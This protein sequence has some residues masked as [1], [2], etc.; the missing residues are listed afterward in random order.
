MTRRSHDG[1]PS[2]SLLARAR[3]RGIAQVQAYF[4]EHP[5]RP[6]E[7]IGNRY[8]I[9][10]EIGRGGF[11]HVYRARQLALGRRLVALKLI[12][13]QRLETHSDGEGAG[14]FLKLFEK[15]AL[16][17]SRLRHHNIVVVFDYGIWEKPLLG[18]LPYLVLEL[19]EGQSLEHR[20]RD[21]PLPLVEA[22]EQVRQ[23]LQALDH[24]HQRGIL[25][26]D[27]K[28]SNLFLDKSGFLKV[29]DFGLARLDTTRSPE[30]ETTELWH[31]VL[32]YAAT[33][34]YLPPEQRDGSERDVGSDLYA[35]GRILID[36][37]SGRRPA[38]ADTAGHDPSA[39]PK[40]S[41]PVLLQELL[42]SALHED[43]AKRFQSAG[44][45]LSMVEMAQAQLRGHGGDEV[46]PY[47]HLAPF[48]RE[49]SS[50]FFGRQR[51]IAA[52]RARLDASSFTVLIGTSGAGKTSLL[53]A[54]LLPTVEVC[55]RV[56]LVE[57]GSRPLTALVERLARSGGISLS[58][59][60]L[61][62]N[63]ELAANALRNLAER[64]G[65]RML[66]VVDQLEECFTQCR[67][68]E[69]RNAFLSILV[70]IANDPR[71]TMSVLVAIREDFLSRL[72]EHPALIEKTDD[73]LILLRPPAGDDLKAALCAPA[74]LRGFFFEPGLADAVL[75]EL[76]TDR[77]AAPLP[78]LQLV[79]T[80]L[81]EG[82][83]VTARQLRHAA[84][85][86][87]DGVAGVL[88]AHA[89]EALDRLRSSD[90][91]RLVP[92]IFCALVTPE[93]TRRTLARDHVLASF[94]GDRAAAEAV[95]ETLISG[96][97]LLSRRRDGEEVIE[98][99]HEALISRWPT[100]RVWLNEDPVVRRL[101]QKLNA[102]ALAWLAQGKPTD[103]LWRGERLALAR[104]WEGSLAH[105]SVVTE[106]LSRSLRAARRR[107]LLLLVGVLVSLT[108][109]LVFAV[110]ERY[111]AAGEARHAKS[112]RATNI[113][114][115][116]TK[117]QLGERTH[118]LEASY[119]KEKQ[120]TEGLSRELARNQELIGS[121]KATESRLR[122]AGR[123]LQETAQLARAK[124]QEAV[125][126]ERDATQARQQADE[127]L[128]LYRKSGPDVMEALNLLEQGRSR[129]ALERV[130]E[131]LQARHL[132]GLDIDEPDLRGLLLNAVVHVSERDAEGRAA[133]E[134][135]LPVADIHDAG[136]A[137]DNSLWLATAQGLYR[138]E[139]DARTVHPVWNRPIQRIALS[140]RHLLLIGQS[141]WVL[142]QP[143]AGLPAA[144]PELRALPLPFASGAGLGAEAICEDQAGTLH[145]A[146]ASQRELWLEPAL[147]RAPYG[148]SAE[149]KAL[150]W[151][152][153][154]TALA[155]G[156]L[157][158]QVH[159]WELAQPFP[160]RRTDS[161][162]G[163]R[164]IAVTALRYLP[165]REHLLALPL[166]G[167]LT[168]LEF[169][170]QQALAAPV[171][172][173]RELMRTL[174]TDASGRLAVVTGS[175]S[176][177]RLWFLTIQR[178]I[179]FQDDG[180]RPLRLARLSPDGNRL[181]LV[182]RDQ[183]ARLYRIDSLTLLRLGQR[184][185]NRG[186]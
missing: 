62:E 94:P 23:L 2:E 167:A 72:G 104:Q 153:A 134:W 78:L 180:G 178:S 31:Q 139:P 27:L 1:G 52:L 43:R 182:S 91:R 141:V 13:P 127:L 54:G 136:F 132:H 71:G 117:E 99:V 171:R 147:A 7:T 131:L 48:E 45:F 64:S 37:L 49:H 123:E 169:D 76:E 41:F 149:V 107:R 161:I 122:R 66:L 154:C 121:L 118:A 159:R 17:T 28:P 110:R 125:K 24:A 35:V 21:G 25:H 162:S 183:T 85:K 46:E 34:C 177:A 68:G 120:L 67:S 20:L 116:R 98:L 15:E 163:G 53:R 26:L 19:L 81:W 16:A 129:Q 38:T 82:R 135:R 142:S 160:S 83:D 10:A 168:R 3:L 113:A 158:G 140:K 55:W 57:P 59:G 114:L 184:L 22:L 90:E 176:T 70:A 88:A 93:S 186:G 11:G 157:D 124:E 119:E 80:K 8:Q 47:R 36:M 95:L 105:G 130:L 174:D 111:R 145:V 170:Q 9:E 77:H 100:L 179:S 138:A 133:A 144:S 12:V 109:L 146:L 6:G 181:L 166:S 156:D 75:H 112:L 137:A 74:A 84:F 155:I 39:L 42:A 86:Q 173:H 33:H 152:A 96:R 143:P 103:L 102:D 164:H 151:S 172:D 40:E 108:A 32:P 69:D 61:R 14:F 185:L 51:N 79:A 87:I 92:E 150:A 73:N 4:C 148:M 101:R 50:L 89:E 5:A 165:V 63:P 115:S 97:L 128:S 58:E 175:D 65:K 126:K 18:K 29:L 44:Q 30:P 60:V 106:F 56:F